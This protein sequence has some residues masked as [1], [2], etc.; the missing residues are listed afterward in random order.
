MQG[1]SDAALLR[2]RQVYESVTE[3]TIYGWATKGW[4]PYSWFVFQRRSL[5]ID[6]LPQVVRP[7]L[8]PE[9]VERLLPLVDLHRAAGEFDRANEVHRQLMGMRD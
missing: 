1:D 7:P 4:N 9:L 8:P 5:P 6:I 2:F 3:Y